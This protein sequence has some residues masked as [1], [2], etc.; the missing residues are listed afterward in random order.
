MRGVK[1]ML[2]KT[3]NNIGK[4]MI[5]MGEKLTATD[6]TGDMLSM[7]ESASTEEMNAAIK[8]W[9]RMYEGKYPWLASDSGKF[10]RTLNLPAIICNSIAKTTFS[11]FQ[12]TIKGKN[13]SDIRLSDTTDGIDHASDLAAFLT[14]ACSVIP[15]N[16]MDMCEYALAGGGM[17]FKPYVTPD[18]TIEIDCTKADSFVPIAFDSKGNITAAGFWEHIKQGK[19]WFH[20]YERHVFQKEMYI[21]TNQAYRSTS[22]DEIGIEVPLEAVDGWA[23]L[24]PYVE[25]GSV[26]FPLFSYWRIPGGNTVDPDSPL[27]VSIFSRG[28]PLIQ[29]ADSRYNDY[30]WEFEATQTAIDASDDLFKLDRNGKLEFPQGRERLFR[31]LDIDA[32]NSEPYHVFS[33][34]IREPELAAGINNT[35]RFCE[36]ACGIAKGT[37]STPL[38]VDKTA[39]EIKNSKQETYITT[40]SIQKSFDKAMK[41]LVLI[42]IKYCELYEL[43]KRD[44]EIEIIT[45]YGDSVLTDSEKERANDRQDVRDGTLSKAE[46][47]MKWRNESKKEAKDKIAEIDRDGSRED[48][49]ELNGE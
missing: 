35:L 16:I 12:L 3:K 36:F 44:D 49:F 37:I 4:A 11:E 41:R 42:C 34:D 8:K 20:R 33:P 45:D 39:E 48:P 46:Y 43:C 18:G 30:D 27:G 21:V 15:D 28:E 24:E 2:D 7:S 19:H 38:Q 17:M 40:S 22:V 25:V 5:I 26:P 9:L 23:Y 13:D 31:A 1:Q 6:R 32:E 14:E 10:Q 47:R 29:D